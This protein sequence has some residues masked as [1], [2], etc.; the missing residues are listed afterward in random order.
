MHICYAS[1]ITASPSLTWCSNVSGSEY[2]INVGVVS[3][4]R[5]AAVLSVCRE[6]HRTHRYPLL[7]AVAGS[8]WHITVSSHVHAGLNMPFRTLILQRISH[9][10]IKHF[11]QHTLK[12]QFITTQSKR[13]L[14]WYRRYGIADTISSAS[15]QTTITCSLSS[16]GLLNIVFALQGAAR[17]CS[18]WVK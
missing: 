12:A 7:M 1:G 13:T 5:L 18:P 8:A 9:Y 4:T 6:P 11:K 14:Q 2:A 17:A 16:L 15:V 10:I 3:L